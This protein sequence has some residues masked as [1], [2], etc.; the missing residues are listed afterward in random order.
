VCFLSSASSFVE[1][2]LVENKQYAEPSRRRKGDSWCYNARRVVES[3][4]STNFLVDPKEPIG[5]HEIDPPRPTD[6]SRYYQ[7]YT[8]CSYS[9]VDKESLL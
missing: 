2:E 4:L 1:A 9:N 8:S 7:S 3:V 5:L 6:R